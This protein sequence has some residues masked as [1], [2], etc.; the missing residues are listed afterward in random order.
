MKGFRILCFSVVIFIF[1]IANANAET[2]MY[3]WSSFSTVENSKANEYLTYKARESLSG[4]GLI[5]DL[6]RNIKLEIVGGLGKSDADV[7]ISQNVTYFGK[8]FNVRKDL[9]YNTGMYQIE[10]KITYKLSKDFEVEAGVSESKNALKKD[11]VMF[12]LI[13]KF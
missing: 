13:Y 7:N 2:K 4:L 5:H 6:N 9:E 12:K 1:A 8:T 11:T 3:L 10:G